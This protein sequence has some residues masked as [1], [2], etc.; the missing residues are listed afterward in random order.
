MENPVIIFGANHLGRAAKEIFETNS[1]VVYGFLDDS[2]KLH[3]TELANGFNPSSA[4]NGILSG[5]NG[6]STF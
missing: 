4:V 6:S 3:N 2:K 1:V 5:P